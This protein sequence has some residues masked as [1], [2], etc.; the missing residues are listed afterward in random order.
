MN[1][2]LRLFLKLLLLTLLFF[3]SC[4]PIKKGD[5]PNILLL[6][7]DYQFCDHLGCSGDPVVK[8][9]NI[10]MIANK[11]YPINLM[12]ISATQRIQGFQGKKSFGI[13]QNITKQK[14]LSQNPDRKQSRFLVWNQSITTFRNKSLKRRICMIHFRIFFLKTC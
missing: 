12:S 6:M 14:I 3:S 5:S 11:N 1:L 10:D 8:T 4:Q 2:N 9:P 13:R 7:S